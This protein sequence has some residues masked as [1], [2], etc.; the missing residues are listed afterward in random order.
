MKT[1]LSAVLTAW[2]AGFALLAGSVLAQQQPAERNET[3]AQPGALEQEAQQEGVEIVVARHYRTADVTGMDVR[4]EEGE[5]LGNIHDLVLDAQTGEVRYA[6]L[7]FGGFLGLGDKLFAI[8]F[9]ALEFHYTPDEQFFVLHVDRETLERAEGFDRDQW[10]DVGDPRWA[11]R[12]DRHYNNAG[13]QQGERDA[14]LTGQGAGARQDL[15]TDAPRAEDRPAGDREDEAERNR[16]EVGQAPPGTAF[17]ASDVRGMNVRNPEGEDLGRIN[18]LVIDLEQGQLNYYAL[19]F[20]GFLRLG[21]K[22]FAIPR[23]AM[24]LRYDPDAED[25]FFVLHVEREKLEQAEGFDR[26]DWPE[27]ADPQWGRD[28]DRHYGFDRDRAARRN[29]L[30]RN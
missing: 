27:T 23:D 4:N 19:S 12:I 10:P 21:D 20:G 5:E 30:R 24:N 2:L 17:R 6:A 29:D 26:N 1:G 13:Q 8:P 16:A 25:Y 7:S 22:L 28:V 11:E 15:E 18:E 3:G 9:H 14:G